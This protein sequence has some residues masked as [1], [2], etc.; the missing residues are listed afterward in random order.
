MK[1]IGVRCI[2]LSERRGLSAG[3]ESRLDERGE[4]RMGA[5]AMS[6][7]R[8]GVLVAVVIVL[9][10]GA[11]AATSAAT[12]TAAGHVCGSFRVPLLRPRLD[13]RVV[14]GRV[15]CRTARTVMRWAYTSYESSFV[16]RH[17][18]WTTY[19]PQTCVAWAKK[20]RKK[21]TGDC[22]AA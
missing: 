5:R 20:G 19:G 14:R 6:N 7:V 9:I 22:G 4:L 16:R 8:R 15:P 3:S 2:H 10:V 21:I 17:D 11:T 18:G 12:S 1:G 13:V